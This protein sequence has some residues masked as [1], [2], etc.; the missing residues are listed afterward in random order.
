MRLSSLI[1]TAPGGNRAVAIDGPKSKLVGYEPT[2]LVNRFGKLFGLADTTVICELKS[3]KLL[4]FNNVDR[5]ANHAFGAEQ[6]VRV[7]AVPDL[8]WKNVKI[9]TPSL[10]IE[11]LS[12]LMTPPDLPPLDGAG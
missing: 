9:R 8:A 7:H 12:G 1:F 11:D 3:G 6:I 4:Q 2:L 10:D 5:F